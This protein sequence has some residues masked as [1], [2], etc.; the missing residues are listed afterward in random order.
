MFGFIKTGRFWRRVFVYFTD[1]MTLTTMKKT[2]TVIFAIVGWMAVLLQYY[3]IMDNRVASALETTIRFFSFFTI[4]TN[5]LAAIY[6]TSRVTTRTAGKVNFFDKPGV[7]TA[8][9]VY[10]TIVGIVYQVVLRHIWEPTGL[11]MLVD[12]LLHSV[13]PIFVI[14]FWFLYEAKGA[15]MWSQV[16]LWMIYPVGYL[17][18]I[19]GRGYMSGF[20]PYPF[21]DVSALG[22]EK[23]LTNSLLLLIVFLFFCALFIVVGKIVFRRQRQQ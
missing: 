2:L 14:V 6:F 3:L 12:E 15:L 13:M 21:M 23:V 17:I 19:L 7:L 20:Y 4:L 18:F 22:L 10:I 16:R 9:T 1:P 8:I 5:A 11:Q